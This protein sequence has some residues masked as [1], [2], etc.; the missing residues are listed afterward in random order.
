[1]SA[2][3]NSLRVKW[4]PPPV[5]R[6]KI[7]QYKVSISVATDLD[8][9]VN[10]QTVGADTTDMHF[11]SL[12]SVTKYNITVHGLTADKKFLWFISGVFDTTD[13]GK[14]IL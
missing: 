2:E 10:E 13:K 8:Q 9:P 12:E 11:R 1:M 6:D 7:S 5:I 14:S 3:H 4:I